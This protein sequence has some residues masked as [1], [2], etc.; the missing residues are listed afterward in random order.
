MHI[1]GQRKVVSLLKSP[2]FSGFA[3]VQL[4]LLWVFLLDCTLYDTI[5]LYSYM[6]ICAC[7]EY[8]I[9]FKEYILSCWYTVQ[10]P[11]V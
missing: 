1:Y 9:Y 3:A 5:M 10:A 11:G 6:I 2:N 8:Y 7:A 4:F